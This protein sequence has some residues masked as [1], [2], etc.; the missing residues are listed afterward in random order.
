MNKSHLEVLY[1]VIGI[2]L[3][4]VAIINAL[5]NIFYIIPYF[6]KAVLMYFTGFM[7]LFLSNYFLYEVKEKRR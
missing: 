2:I 1:K 6:T 4:L 5:E 3:F 7:L